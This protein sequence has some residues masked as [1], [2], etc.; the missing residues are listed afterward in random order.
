MTRKTSVPKTLKR[1]IHAVKSTSKKISKAVSKKQKDRDT[2]ASKR[3]YTL[4]DLPK[5]KGR[6]FGALT[7]KVRENADELDKLLK[8]GEMWAYEIGSDDSGW[9]RSWEPFK[10][11]RDA[12]DKL[13]YGQSGRELDGT[14]KSGNSW[15]KAIKII[16]FGKPIK[17]NESL[18]AHEFLETTRYKNIKLRQSKK[19][20]KKQANIL[21][22]ASEFVIGKGENKVTTKIDIIESLLN[23]AKGMDKMLDDA[24]KR[25]AAL[26]K[27]LRQKSKPS[28]KA[29]H[30][31]AKK[32][33]QKR[34]KK[35]VKNVPSKRAVSKP[36]K[37]ATKKQAT[38][39]QTI[40]KKFA[41]KK[42]TVKKTNKNASKKKAIK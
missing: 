42:K 15:I 19:R 30:K 35:E 13:E 41:S 14:R 40:T 16:K 20:V 33:V 29:V 31:P 4:R 17:E 39:K 38:R 11:I 24:N 36:R 22:K 12:I 9:N 3:S 26:E 25:I 28:K 1:N 5:V 2:F 23:T 7:E 6:T 10:S 32:E 27:A 21:T 8:P 34:A 18:E 37:Q